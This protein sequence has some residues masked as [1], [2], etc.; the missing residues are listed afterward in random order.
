MLIQRCY[1]FGSYIRVEHHRSDV[2]AHSHTTII[3]RPFVRTKDKHI[4][5]SSNPNVAVYGALWSLWF[6]HHH[7]PASSVNCPQAGLA[8]FNT[9][10]PIQPLTSTVSIGNNNMT[11]ATSVMQ[12]QQLATK[13]NHPGTKT[14]LPSHRSASPSHI[15][16]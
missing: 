4:I 1:I 8:G 7:Q 10:P 16:R 5:G 15:T 2:V 3:N 12:R 11:P 14:T 13:W 6:D 9:T